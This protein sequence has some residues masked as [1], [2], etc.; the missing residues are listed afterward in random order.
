MVT[1]IKIWNS[2]IWIMCKFQ[3]LPQNKHP[4]S[5]M[6]LIKLRN[7]YYCFMALKYYIF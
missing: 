4:A 7:K 6:W 5:I 3:F 2:D 1:L